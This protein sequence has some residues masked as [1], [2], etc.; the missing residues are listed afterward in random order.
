MVNNRPY[1]LLLEE[2]R[3]FLY[4]NNMKNSSKKYSLKT[5]ILR[6]C[7]WSKALYELLKIKKINSHIIIVDSMTKQKY[8]TNII[9]TFPQL[10]LVDKKEHIIGGYD[11]TK[12]LL[13]IINENKPNID[14]IK[15][16]FKD[17]LPNLNDKLILKLI[18]LLA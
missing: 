10:Y 16:K 5:I 3:F 12:R 7:S 14:I 17:I 9:D 1:L 2:N 18:I 6:D 13:D 8:K 4:I 11:T 15:S